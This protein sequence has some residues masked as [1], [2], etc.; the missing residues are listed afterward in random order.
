MVRA[1]GVVGLFVPPPKADEQIVALFFHG[2]VDQIT[3]G[4]MIGKE[5]VSR[6]IGTFAAEYPGYGLA[7]GDPTEASIDSTPREAALER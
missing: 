7:G 4:A 6:G 5:R 2:N 3:W 1:D